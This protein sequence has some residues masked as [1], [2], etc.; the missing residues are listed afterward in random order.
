MCSLCV[1]RVFMSLCVHCQQ[2]LGMVVYLILLS[3]ILF[4]NFVNITI[5][6]PTTGNIQ[7]CKINPPNLKLPS[8]RYYFILLS[9]PAPSIQLLVHYQTYLSNSY[10]L[11][12]ISKINW[13]CFQ[14][15]FFYCC[16]TSVL[17]SLN[18][19]YVFESFP[20]MQC[21]LEKKQYAKK[22]N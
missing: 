8:S 16:I 5:L 15:H 2:W 11:G 7:V 6:K 10:K 22:I 13:K 14:E 20:T 12:K 21:F 4:A 17:E 19:N 3:Y 1:H 18:F 9:N